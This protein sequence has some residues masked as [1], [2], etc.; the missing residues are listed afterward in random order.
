MWDNAKSGGAWEV[1]NAK[2]KNLIVWSRHTT[3]TGEHDTETPTGRLL[4][5]T[6]AFR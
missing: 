6:I 1:R 5:T 2:I 3:S 4:A